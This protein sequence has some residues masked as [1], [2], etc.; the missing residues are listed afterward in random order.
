[1]KNINLRFKKKRRNSKKD[2]HKETPTQT[3]HNQSTESQRQKSSES[4]ER[5]TNHQYR[6][7]TTWLTTDFST[8]TRV[9]RQHIQTAERKRKLVNKIFYIYQEYPSES[10]T[11]L[12]HSQKNKN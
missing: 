7:I 6:K 5:K 1:M 8:K 10:K 12:R 4:H 11:K 9:A 3:H 2:K